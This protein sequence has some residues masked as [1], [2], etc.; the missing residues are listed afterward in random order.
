MAGRREH[1]IALVNRIGAGIGRGCA[2]RFAAEG[3]RVVGADIDAD[4]A[5]A[6]VAEGHRRGLEMTSVHPYDL[7]SPADARRSV[8]AAVALE[9]ASTSW[10]TPAPSRPV[11]S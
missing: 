9:G 8:A 7:T 2:L 6:T 10:S 1:K 3:A 11:S 5:T 4:S